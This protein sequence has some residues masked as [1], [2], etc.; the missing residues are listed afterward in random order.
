MYPQHGNI[1]DFFR[2]IMAVA[3]N[4]TKPLC[5]ID[6]GAASADHGVFVCH[7]PCTVK[8]LLF[9]VTLEAVSGTVTAPTVVF[10]KRIIANS[11]SGGSAMGTLTIPSGTGIGKTVYK[12]ITPVS[13]KVGDCIN[14]AWTIGTGTPTG[15]GNAEIY[16][17]LSSEVPGNEPD[18]IASA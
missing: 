7:R 4:D 6:I 8:Q 1:L 10:T 15:M 11:A 18:M 5:D 2:P 9:A 14:I 13:F 3:A 12:F 17:E 16:A